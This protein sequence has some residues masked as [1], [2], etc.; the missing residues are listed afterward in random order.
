MYDVKFRKKIYIYKNYH[1]N[2]IKYT[3]MRNDVNIIIKKNSSNIA[4][5]DD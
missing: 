2:P 4:I 1:E 5:Q 3:E